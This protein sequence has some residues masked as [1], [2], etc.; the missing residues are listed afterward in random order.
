MHSL[1]TGSAVAV[2]RL[3]SSHFNSEKKFKVSCGIS[4]NLVIVLRALVLR[5]VSRNVV[6]KRV[7]RAE[8]PEIVW[9]LSHTSHI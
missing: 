9:Q 8:K 5:N 4:L 7:A 2:S 6:G 1:L 3:E